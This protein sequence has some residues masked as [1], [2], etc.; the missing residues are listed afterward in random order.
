[1]ESGH[2]AKV[3]VEALGVAPGC[4]LSELRMAVTLASITDFYFP[5]GPGVAV[6]VGI[7]IGAF[8]R[9]LISRKK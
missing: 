8:L 3:G 6:L 9:M 5:G 7:V 1:M 4:H 2:R